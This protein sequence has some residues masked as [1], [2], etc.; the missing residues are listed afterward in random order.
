MRTDPTLWI[1]ARTSGLL[2]YALLTSSVLAGLVLKARPFGGAVKAAAVTD[3]HRL[4]ALLGLGAM[5]GHA[6][7]L[8]LDSS[9]RFEIA[10]L[11]VP[12]LGPYR[13]LWTGLGVLA[14]EL[15]VI[16]YASFSLRKRIGARTWRRLHW[17]T[18]LIF[19]IATIHG[20]A[21]GTDSA[22]AWAVALYGGAVG[23][24]V[25]A[26]GWRILVPPT[27][28]DR[29][30]PRITPVCVAEAD[31][32]QTYQA[33]GAGSTPGAAVVVDPRGGSAA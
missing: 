9:F 8:L 22:R 31:A 21:A 6:L 33:V 19:C 4:L 23:A 13:P 2:A 14:A 15:T 17:A 12:G 5:L 16:V 18:Y 28:G 25:A 26:A 1:L 32:A 20:L 3:I 11:L 29:R 30:V 7:A 27:K 24:V 10:D